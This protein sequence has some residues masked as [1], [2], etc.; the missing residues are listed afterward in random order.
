VRHFLITPSDLGVRGALN[1]GWTAITRGIQYLIQRADSHASFYFVD[2]LSY[3]PEAWGLAEA[4]AHTLSICGNPRLGSSL[5]Q[6][7]DWG[8]WAHLQNVQLRGIRTADL[9]AGVDLPAPNPSPEDIEALGNCSEV[10]QVLAW[11]SKL[12]LVVSRDSIFHQLAHLAGVE[13]TRLPCSSWWAHHYWGIIPKR[14]R[15][16]HVIVIRLPEGSGDWL[17]AA[18]VQLQRRLAGDKKTFMVTTDVFAYYQMREAGA[19]PLWH[20]ADFPSMLRMYAEADILVSLRLHSSVPALS[21]GARV[22]NIA[23]DARSLTLE[24]FGVRSKTLTELAD[25]E[26]DPL[27][28]WQTTEFGDREAAE[29]EDLFCDVFRSQMLT[30]RNQC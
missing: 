24:A 22:I 19:D 4:H 14:D 10:Q 13:H 18:L 28:D 11:E 20:A 27:T 6:Y 7:Y 16:H 15:G 8:F 1:P 9:F 23:T 25:G 12:D 3:V 29:A 17:P 30:G 2:M 26:I 21:V 5:K